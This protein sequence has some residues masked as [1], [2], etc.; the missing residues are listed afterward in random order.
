MK[1]LIMRATTTMKDGRKKERV[2]NMYL[3]ANM[4]DFDS[5]TSLLIDL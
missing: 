1:T 5:S 4:I 2:V 3:D